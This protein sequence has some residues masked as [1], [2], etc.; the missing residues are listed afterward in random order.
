MVQDALRKASATIE[1]RIPKGWEKGK[2]QFGWL[3]I[4]DLQADDLEDMGVFI[5][6]VYDEKIIQEGCSVKIPVIV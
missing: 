4:P 3:A 6:K 5:G 1:R 2:G